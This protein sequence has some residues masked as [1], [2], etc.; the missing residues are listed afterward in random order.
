MGRLTARE[1]LSGEA[2]RRESPT[3]RALASLAPDAL[4][5]A[6][7]DVWRLHIASGEATV[8]VL[9]AI[10]WGRPD[11]DEMRRRLGAEWRSWHAD[12]G[13]ELRPIPGGPVE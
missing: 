13:L 1:F 7:V 6:A 10:C 8:G 5:E 9:Q 4:P 11:T 2:E 3:R 12:R